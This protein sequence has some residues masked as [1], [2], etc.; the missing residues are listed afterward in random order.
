MCAP[1]S[2]A[3]VFEQFSYIESIMNF[4]VYAIK[5]KI[6]FFSMEY[7]S[8]HRLDKMDPGAA[9]PVIP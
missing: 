7:L 8:L 1:A 6:N 9:G 2:L 3:F 5:R 4:L